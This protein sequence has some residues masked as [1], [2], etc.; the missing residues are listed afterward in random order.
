VLGYSIVGAVGASTTFLLA[1]VLRRIAPRIG[2]VALPGARSVHA[3]PIASLGGAAMFLGFLA[4][5][6]VASQLD[7]FHGMFADS[8]EPLG[9]L[10]GGGVMFLSPAR[11]T[12]CGRCHHRPRSRARSSPA[13]CSPSSA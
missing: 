8:S 9:I 12:I 4:A 1:F 2:A 7:Q 6:A 5:M 13:A 3:E 10:L 11:S